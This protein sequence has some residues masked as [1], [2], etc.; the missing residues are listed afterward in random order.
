MLC[1][2]CG[3][4]VEPS[5]EQ[6]GECENC[7]AEIQ[8]YTCGNKTGGYEDRPK[9]DAISEEEAL[10]LPVSDLELSDITTNRL[11]NMD[12][13][14]TRDLVKKTEV[15][16]RNIRSFGDKTLNKIKKQLQIFGLALKQQ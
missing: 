16:L 2:K 3:K 5:Y 1:K 11:S 4:L 10:A 14:Y 9:P 8:A 13:I 12:I 7:F 6:I 15:E